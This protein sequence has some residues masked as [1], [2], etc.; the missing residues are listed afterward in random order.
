[1]RKNIARWLLFSNCTVL[2]IAGFLLIA[3]WIG[4]RFQPS[5]LAL[6]SE[7][8]RYEATPVQLDWKPTALSLVRTRQDMMNWGSTGLRIVMLIAF[9]F[10]GV[11]VTNVVCLRK[12]A[13]DFERGSFA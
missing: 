2:A 13:R 5:A 4:T 7:I 11:A 9:G 3:A 6:R 12:L 8:T 10:G 1:M